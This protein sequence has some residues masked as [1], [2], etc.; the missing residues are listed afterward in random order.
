MHWGLCSNR[1]GES[2]GLREASVSWE[3][4][5]LQGGPSRLT[6]EEVWCCRCIRMGDSAL[7]P[8]GLH[9]EGRQQE[10]Q[11][12]G[13]FSLGLSKAQACLSVFSIYCSGLWLGGNVGPNILSYTCLKARKC[14][15]EIC[16]SP[17]SGDADTDMFRITKPPTN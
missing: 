7:H 17:F 4:W 9:R 8:I 2:E 12:R 3:R 16:E 5:H 10:E 11:V 13:T 1:G 14:G 6:T 15:S